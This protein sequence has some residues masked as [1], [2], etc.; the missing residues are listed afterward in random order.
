MNNNNSY[1][2]FRKLSLDSLRENYHAPVIVAEQLQS[3]E[4]IGAILRL[5]G[6]V[7]A[8]KVIFLYNSPPGYKRYK[9][10]KHAS[11]A[12]EKVQW[13]YL[14]YEKLEEELPDGYHWVA[15]ETTPDA[16]NIYNAR[17]PGK[18]VFFVGNE[19]YGLS[20]KLLKLMD[21]RY[22]IPVPGTVSSLNVSQALSVALFEWL[23]QQ[24]FAGG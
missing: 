15:I 14:S 6:N 8:R 22:F 1:R 5:A 13:E 12:A 11:G 17:L 20:D 18:V 9:I 4:N 10:N 2:L 16:E 19:R 21:K 7:A 3:P 24:L 23:R